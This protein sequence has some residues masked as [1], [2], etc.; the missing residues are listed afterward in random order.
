MS[1]I[2]IG[3]IITSPRFVLGTRRFT[4]GDGVN[5]PRIIASSKP[6]LVGGVGGGVFTWYENVE[7]TEPAEDGFGPWTV[8][9]KRERLFD[10]TTRDPARATKLYAIYDINRSPDGHDYPGSIRV[11]ARAE[12]GEEI[13]FEAC[14][15]YT[16]SIRD[17]EITVVGTAEVRTVVTMRPTTGQEVVF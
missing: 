7:T 4:H 6:L 5:P 3:N 11:R 16:G 10:A 8:T 17:D 13:E 1:K 15:G 2:E 14:S 12:D 9:K